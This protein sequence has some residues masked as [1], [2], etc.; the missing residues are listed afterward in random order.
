MTNQ[1]QTFD[2]LNNAIGSW[3]PPDVEESKADFPSD[4]PLPWTDIGE[5]GCPA[6]PLKSTP[7]RA[8]GVDTVAGDSSIDGGAL[9]EAVQK[10]GFEALAFYKSFRHRLNG[11]YPGKWGVF[12]LE[13][14]ISL[15]SNLISIY[16]PNR[17]GLT[18]SRTLGLEFLRRHE[19]YH[20][21]VDVSA[22]SIEPPM[23]KHL[24]L[25]FRYAYRN[26]ASHCIE[27]ALANARAWKWAEKVDQ[28]NNGLLSFAEDFMSGQPNAYR[29]FVEDPLTLNAEFSANLIDQHFGRMS[30]PKLATWMRNF[31]K[32][33]ASRW[34]PEYVICGASVSLLFPAVQ[35]FPVVAR[36]VE[37][38]EVQKT[39]KK[40][41]SDLARKWEKTK[42]KLAVCPSLGGL[43]FKQWPPIQRAWSVR[44]DRGYRA[45]LIPMPTNPGEWEAIEIGSHDALGH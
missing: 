15:V 9:G 16:V 33:L 29:R 25:P 23:C 36:V 32:N 18:D 45:H 26:C 5:K 39:L 11:P 38:E 13:Q 37:S 1:E 14:G 4:D 42:Q 19:I 24:Y 30:N 22:L 7:Q 41:G 10:H 6:E 40:H 21:L 34:V 28:A 35:I 31:Q 43:D 27:E 2:A 20:Y 12:Y 3:T 17:N 8:D 44:V